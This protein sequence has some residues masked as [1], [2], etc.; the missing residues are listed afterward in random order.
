MAIPLGDWPDQQRLLPHQAN[1]EEGLWLRHPTAEVS[2][3]AIVYPEVR[4][5]AHSHVRERAT[6]GRA[7]SIGERCYIAEDVTIG[8]KSRV[9]N[10][11]NVWKGV[12]I[13]ERVFIGPSVVFCNDKHPRVRE[14]WA[15]PELT[16]I[17][18]DVSIGAGAIIICGVR[19][20]RGAR[21]AAGARIT[22]DVMEGE[23]WRNEPAR[24]VE[25]SAA[26]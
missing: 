25:R 23:L 22:A 3:Q 7:V 13:G 11:V 14:D 16:V 26:R 4:V 21:I 2:T 9:G 24:M 12:T 20:G 1:A 19:I 10:G 17:E 5:W 18:D 6:L 15:G 8:E